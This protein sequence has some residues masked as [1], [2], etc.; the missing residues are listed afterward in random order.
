[1]VNLVHPVDR[2][3][4]VNTAYTAIY[5]NR[6]VEIDVIGELVDLH[7]GNGLARLVTLAHQRQL[8]VIPQ[9]LIVA[10][11][12]GRGGRDVRVPGFLD[13]V[14]TIAAIDPQLIGMDG[15]RKSHRLNG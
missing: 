6:M 11:H 12:A 13:S 9:N 15:M 5:M 8:G 2:S 7:P 14:V 1:M 10:I 3:V 4:A